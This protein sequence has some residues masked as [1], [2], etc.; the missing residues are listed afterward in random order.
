MGY[1][2]GRDIFQFFTMTG[3]NALSNDEARLKGYAIERGRYFPVRERYWLDGLNGCSE[4]SA[5][6]VSG[7]GHLIDPFWA[8][9]N[10]KV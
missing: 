2:S 7:Y 4:H 9:L 3:D 5:I 10:A 1:V 8:Y 6:F